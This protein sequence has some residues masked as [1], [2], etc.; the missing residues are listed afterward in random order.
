MLF[1]V[2]MCWRGD[3]AFSITQRESPLFHK[4]PSSSS[5]LQVGIRSCRAY[6]A[7]CFGS[8]VQ[9]P[10]HLLKTHPNHSSS[11]ICMT[12]FYYG[13]R[14]TGVVRRASLNECNYLNVVPGQGE[15]MC[16]A[17]ADQLGYSG[18]FSFAGTTTKGRS[19]SSSKKKSRTT[20]QTSLIWLI[21]Y[22]E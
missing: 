14:S 4:Q 19:E 5:L 15:V 10:P 13:C 1:S 9:H 20:T 3:L 12:T 7:R 11:D 2:R 8:A 6:R 18:S 22:F 21:D 16:G 17:C